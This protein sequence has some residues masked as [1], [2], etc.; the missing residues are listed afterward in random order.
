ME[1]DPGGFSLRWFSSTVELALCGHGTLAAA[2]VLREEG[3][4]ASDDPLR[5]ETRAGTL[6]A[7]REGEWIDLDFPAEPPEETV[8]PPDLLR[9]LGVEP[10]YVGANRLDNL[11]VVED[12][13][14]VRALRPDLALLATVPTRRVIVTAP[15][16]SGEYTFVSLT[17]GP[18]P[19]V[20]A[21]AAIGLAEI[22]RPEGA[23][24][25]RR[26][27]EEDHVERVRNI[28]KQALDLL[29]GEPEARR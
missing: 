25:I 6:L 18:I 20:R 23:E 3:E 19:F 11:V 29:P 27:A 7:G 21:H 22:G 12:E 2:H 4:A 9:A 14:A 28:A 13:E 10:A 15:A 5:F 8:P 1:R 26:L 17:G 16:A 24:A